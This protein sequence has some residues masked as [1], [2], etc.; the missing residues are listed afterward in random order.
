MVDDLSEGGIIHGDLNPGN[1]IVDENMQPYIID[2]DHVKV[3]SNKNQ[4]LLPPFAQC[5][6]AGNAG[7][8]EDCVDRLFASYEISQ[9]IIATRGSKR[10][11]VTYCG[12]S[13][14]GKP[15]GKASQYV[16]I[17]SRNRKVVLMGR[18]Q[19]CMYQGELCKLSDLRKLEKRLNKEKKKARK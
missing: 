5:S 6:Q 13:G 10:K 12:P 15:N 18:V 11:S 8:A 14:G 7:K 17:L 19:Y 9:E 16:F 4:D 2:F 1:V 3:Y